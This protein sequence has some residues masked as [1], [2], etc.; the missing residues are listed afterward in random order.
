MFTSK[1]TSLFEVPSNG[2]KSSKTTSPFIAAG[3]KKAAQ[4][5]SGNNSLKYSTTGNDFVDQFGTAGS[6][7]QPRDYAAISTDTSKLWAVS[8]FK[9]MAFILYLRLITRVVSLFDG[10][11][12]STPQR[13][14]GLKHE[15][16]FRMIW[17]AVNHP[18]T[19]YKNLHLF[20][21][22]GSWK[23][24]I[25]MLS[26]DLIYNGWDGRVL[27]WN[28]M[29]K[30]ILAGLEN[31]KTNNLVK[32]YL[33][34][35][36]SNSAC[37]TPEA[38]ADNIIA[39]W[40][41]S[42]LF[43]KKESPAN[44]KKY[45]KLKTSGTAHEWQ[46]LISQGNLLNID[47]STIHGR[48]L[49]LLVSGKFL[50]NNNLETKYEKFLEKQPI[51]KYTGYVYELLGTISKAT[52]KYQEETINKQFKQLVETAKKGAKQG[53]SLIVVR[54][55]SG[56]MSST[57]SGTNMSCGDVAKSLALFFSEML[58]AGK[59]ANS[60]IEFNANA[61]MHTWKGSTVV[62]KWRNDNTGY[63]G[64]TDFQSVINLFC[65]IKGEGIPESE[66]PTGI[67]CIS[68]GEFDP[69]TSLRK[70]NVE[71]ALEKL[72]KAGFSQSYIDNFQI[73]LWNLQSRHY[74]DSTGK[75]FETYG[76]VKNVY[77]LSG[78]DGATIAFLTGLEGSDKIPQ[79]AEELFE[80]AMN[81]EVMSLI[82][83]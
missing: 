43:G 30:F 23:D 4:T 39:K 21:S 9:T 37:K 6:Y 16:I 46:K 47:F 70:T 13:G 25:T 83:A 49:S 50:K 33:P 11:K 45:R 40:I 44:Y 2:T 72:K 76:N 38:Q 79:T 26:Y 15:G 3:M 60:W 19:F 71:Q 55:T 73:M 61:K 53:T 78:L 59:F 24:I 36:K 42:L 74:G 52:K 12:T 64:N 51:L 7:K 66:F 34:Q 77:Y 10:N 28:K 67:L 31:P 22:V 18:N 35:I 75:K 82:E 17:V 69:G 8:P 32:K 14:Q 20:I 48:A 54:D 80:A 57:A 81:Q 58:P 65:K 1:K 5:R 63:V 27:D 56:S 29:G 62:E 41:S 68:D